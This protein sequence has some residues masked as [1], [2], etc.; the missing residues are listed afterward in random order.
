MKKLFAIL[1]GFAFNFYVSWACSL[2][3]GNFSGCKSMTTNTGSVFDWISQK[4]MFDSD[5]AWHRIT[6]L[7]NNPKHI[8]VASLCWPDWWK[9]RRAQAQS[10]QVPVKVSP[11]G[12]FWYYLNYQSEFMLYQCF[13]DQFLEFVVPVNILQIQIYTGFFFHTS[14][15]SLNCRGC[16]SQPFDLRASALLCPE[17][18]LCP[19]SCF[20]LCPLHCP[21]MAELYRKTPPTSLTLSYCLILCVKYYKNVERRV[22]PLCLFLFVLFNFY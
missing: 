3:S 6:F 21:I 5:Q 8:S 10:L 18:E 7:G 1:I 4:Y 17:T 14:S 11:S 12:I 13:S 22:F 2:F 20:V 9:S 19:L 16:I 15:D